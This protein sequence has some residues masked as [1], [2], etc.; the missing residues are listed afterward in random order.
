MQLPPFSLE[1]YFARHEFAA[2]RLLCASDCESMSI[3]ELLAMEPGAEEGFREQRL[4]YTESQGAPALRAAVRGLYGSASEEEILALSGAE[5]GIFLFMHAALSPGDHLVVHQPC[6]QSL[7]E[8]ARSIGCE[9]TA[10]EAREENGWA[11]DPSDLP[12][13]TRPGTRAIVLN[14]PHNPTGFLMSPGAFGETLRFAERHGIVVFSDEV[15]RGLEQREADR[16]PAAFQASPSAVSLGV[17]SKT[18]GLPG[19]RIG[20][21]ATRNRRLLARMAEL[22]DYTTICGSAPSE[23]LA[24]VALRHAGEIARHNREIIASNLRL[25]DGF[26]SRRGDVFSWRRPNAGPVAFP[27]LLRGDV[28]SFCGALLEA[29]G[30]LLAP[31]GLFGGRAGHFRIGFGRKN[32]PEALAD[33]EGFLDG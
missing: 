23:F 32:M 24:E 16:L 9:A 3:G 12:R 26:F 20:W 28:E 10:W 31:G 7:V 8:V 6:Y 1:R 13:L 22:K 11:I 19:L 4:G 14:V 5:E 33:L 30:V 29:R 21:V 2:R 18:F 27:R 25:L 17:M 15:Y